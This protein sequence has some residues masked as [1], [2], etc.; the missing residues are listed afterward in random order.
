[1]SLGRRKHPS[2]QTFLGLDLPLL[3][4]RQQ[5]GHENG[6]ENEW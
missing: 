1:M 2:I 6:N 4:R 5:N 3:H